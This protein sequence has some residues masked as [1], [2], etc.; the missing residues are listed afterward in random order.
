L[1]PSAKCLPVSYHSFKDRRP[2]DP[3]TVANN[4]HI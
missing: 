1:T 4:P 3:K 2:L